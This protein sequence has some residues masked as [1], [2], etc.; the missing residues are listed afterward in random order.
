M[1]VRVARTWKASHG[2]QRIEFRLVGSGELYD[3]VEQWI[4]EE[5]LDD[6]VSLSPAID[7]PISLY[8]WADCLMMTSRYEGIPFVIYQAMSTGLPAV[9]PIRDTSNP[10]ILTRDDAYFVKQQNSPAEYVTAIRRMST[11]QMKSDLKWNAQPWPL[12]PM[13]ITGISVKC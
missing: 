3:E 12:A 6:I 5:E 10:E 8:E 11:D 2:S 1:A 4:R 7:D 9:T 13:Y